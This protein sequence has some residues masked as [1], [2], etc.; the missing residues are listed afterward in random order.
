M[1]FT[2]N[3]THFGKH[4]YFT[5]FIFIKYQ[6]VLISI[7]SLFVIVDMF[8]NDENQ[9]LKFAALTISVFF[10]SRKFYTMYLHLAKLRIKI[11]EIL[12]EA[13]NDQ[14]AVVLL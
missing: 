10:F 5:I 3:Q 2:F 13:Q 7:I 14:I 8:E 9:K 11:H 12:V 6:P 4:V 1:L